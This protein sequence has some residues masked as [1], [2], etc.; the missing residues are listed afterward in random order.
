MVGAFNSGVSIPAS[1]VLQ[2][3]GIVAGQPGLHGDQVH[4]ARQLEHLPHLRARRPAG[5]VAG[6]YL[7]DKFKGKKIAFVHDKTPYGKG[8]ADETLKAL[9]AK[10]GT[11]VIYEGINPGEKDFSALVSKLKQAG[12]D[13]VYFG[14]LYTEAGLLIRQMR[15]Q[16]LQRA[17]DG[18][19][20]HRR[21][22]V[23]ADGRP[24]LRRHPDDLLAGCPQEPEG[25]GHRRRL[26]GRRTSIPR[27]TPSIPTPPCRSCSTR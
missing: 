10:G 22:R 21:P 27:A 17:A 26:Q 18:R 3:A 24:G 2:E 15:D 13:V 5:R 19:R 6:A 16:S 1:D 25:Q 7:A 9:K 12:V 4:R 8:L 11:N 23:R 20:R 14:G